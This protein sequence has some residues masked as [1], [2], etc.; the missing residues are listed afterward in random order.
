MAQSKVICISDYGKIEYNW[1][2]KETITMKA[3]EMEHHVQSNPDVFEW[4]SASNVIQSYINQGWE[5]M[6]ITPV[7]GYILVYFE[8]I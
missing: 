5:V 8:R 3:W 2:L 1:A 4:T 6:Q 7:N